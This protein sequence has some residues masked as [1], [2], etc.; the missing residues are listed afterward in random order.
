M[1]FDACKNKVL[2]LPFEL[3]IGEDSTIQVSAGESIELLPN[4]YYH[5]SVNMTWNEMLTGFFFNIYTENQDKIDTFYLQKS[6]FFGPTYLHAPPE[7]FKHFCC[8]KL[9][10]GSISETDS[11]GIIRFR[12]K[13]KNGIPMSNLKFYNKLGERIKTEVYDKNGNLKR[14]K[15]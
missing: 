14:I 5:L 7:E 13:F 10:D 3:W 12:G 4:N 11:N 9:C 6:R 15:N 8:D 2:E 1:F